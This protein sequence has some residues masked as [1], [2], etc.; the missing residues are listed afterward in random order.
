[1]TLYAVYD[2]QVPR[3]M[4]G[5]HFPTIT[6]RIPNIFTLRVNHPPFMMIEFLYFHL[7]EMSRIAPSV[8][9]KNVLIFQAKLV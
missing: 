5:P 7:N 1:M 9:L 2:S 6:C 4:A 3:W 8:A